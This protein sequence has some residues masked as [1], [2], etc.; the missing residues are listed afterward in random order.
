MPEGRRENGDSTMAEPNQE[1]WRALYTV[2]GEFGQLAPWEWMTDEHLFAV[3]SPATGEVGYCSV[4][5]GGGQEFGLAVFLGAEGFAAY[6]KLMV[7]DLE[8][9]SVE[10]AALLRSLSVTLVD[11]EMLDRRDLEVIRSLGLRFRGRGA[12]PWFRSQRPGYAPWFLEQDEARFL[13]LALRQAIEVS[14]WAQAGTLQLTS[15]VDGRPVLTRCLREDTWVDQWR[16]PPTWEP[17][18]EEP[19]PVDA[20][21]LQRL[22]E[23]KRGGR[24]VWQLDFSF[25]PAPIGAR[26]ER[27]YFPCLL[28]AVSP[29]GLVL[30]VQLLEPWSSA[31]ERQEAVLTVLEGAPL[32]PREILVGREE[33]RRL[34]GP[35]AQGLGIRLRT[36]RITDLAALEAIK[37]ELLEQVTQA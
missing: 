19:K 6:R 4:I 16:Q 18:R 15:G 37:E 12:W 24:G 11:R 5:G 25:L 28:L 14:R 34:V 21:R 9:E 7:A 2:T 20:Q 32:L 23:A 29:E 17:P 10:A 1:Q 33:V 35:L 27:P 3:E 8:P 31:T 22:R 30:G 13:E 36:A 26:G